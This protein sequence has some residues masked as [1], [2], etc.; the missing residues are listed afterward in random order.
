MLGFCKSHSHWSSRSPACPLPP[1]C[2]F[3][4]PKQS[5]C[6]APYL[7]VSSPR[8]HP[9]AFSPSR[10][11]PPVCV[12]RWRCLPGWD[13]TALRLCWLQPKARLWGVGWCLGTSPCQV[14]NSPLTAGTQPAAGGVTVPGGVHVPAT[15]MHPHAGAHPF[16][17]A[18]KTCGWGHLSPSKPCCPQ[19]HHPGATLGSGEGDKQPSAVAPATRRCRSMQQDASWRS[20]TSLAIKSCCCLTHPRHGQRSALLSP[21]WSGDLG[22]PG[23]PHPNTPPCR[24]DGQCLDTL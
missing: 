17:R 14:P 20:E 21:G 16:L 12:P 3:P 5:A 22:C 1:R 10:L 18:H 15:A 2:R 8:H 9:S 7:H 6:L 24:S 19:G 13:T 11:Y 4:N 23:N